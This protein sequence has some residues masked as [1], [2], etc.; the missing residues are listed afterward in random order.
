MRHAFLAHWIIGGVCGGLVAMGGCNSGDLAVVQN[1]GD[2]A[3]DAPPG[4][5]KRDAAT[6][7]PSAVGD[8]DAAADAPSVVEDGDTG[9][10]ACVSVFAEDYDRSCTKDSDCVTVIIGGSPCDDPC[11]DQ[12]QNYICDI[13]PVSTSGRQSYYAALSA[14][15]GWPD[16]RLTSCNGGPPLAS[17]PRIGPPICVNGTCTNQCA[18]VTGSGASQE[19]T[20]MGNVNNPPFGLPC[21]GPFTNGSCPSS[22]LYGCCRETTTSDGGEVNV[23]GTCYYS[24]DGGA[25]AEA[26]CLQNQD[27]GLPYTW[28]TNVP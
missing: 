16:G 13:E 25:A 3:A 9:P 28:E 26:T 15:F 24:S 21:S 14:V 11:L 2:G 7:A 22:N 1:G 12:T 19:C 5:G 18:Q 10:D 6:D 27:A 23:T 4:T 17:C 8:D 20:Y